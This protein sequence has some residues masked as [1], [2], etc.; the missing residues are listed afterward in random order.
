MSDRSSTYAS[1]RATEDTLDSL[2]QVK[3]AIDAAGMQTKHPRNHLEIEVAQMLLKLRFWLG[4]SKGWIKIGEIGD[5]RSRMWRSMPRSEASE[6]AK[7]QVRLRRAMAHL[8][9]NP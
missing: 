7:E 1:A 3:E 8:I 5:I 6:R 9:M 2:A 4:G